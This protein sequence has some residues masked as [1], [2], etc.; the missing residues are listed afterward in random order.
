LAKVELRG[1]E[2]SRLG[3]CHFQ[4]SEEKAMSD[5]LLTPAGYTVVLAILMFLTILTVGLSF[6][7]SSGMTRIIA[8]QS[9]AVVKASF[10]VLFFMHALRSSAQTRAVIAVTVFWLVVV[11]L[12]LTFTDYSTRGMLPNLPGH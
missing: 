12:S 7:P 4:G 3:Q 2:K 6:V 8:G 5:R 9:I 10:V 11:L 1:R